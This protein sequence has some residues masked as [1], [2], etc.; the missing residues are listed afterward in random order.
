MSLADDD[1]VD[2]VYEAAAVGELW[3]DVLRELAV[4]TGGLGSVM[5]AATPNS[6]RWVASAELQQFITDWFREG[7]AANNTRGARLQSAQAAG[8]LRDIDVFDSRDQ[9]D[10]DPQVRDFLRPRGMGWAVGTVLSVPNGD[11]IIFSIEREYVKG[12]FEDA[13]VGRLDV[14]RPHLARAAVLSSR[15]GFERA[16]AVAQALQAVGLPTAVL[17]TGGR[18]AATNALFDKLMPGVIEDRRSRVAL[19]NRDSDRLLETALAKLD[20]GVMQGEV[21]SIAV[22]AAS[23]RSPMAL[24]LIPVCGVAHDIFSQAVSILIATPVDRNASPNAE[25]L[26][27]LFDLTRTEARIARAIAQAQSI[28]EIADLYGV[29]TGTVRNQL[30]SI[31]AKTGTGRQVELVRLLSGLAMRSGSD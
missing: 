13:V 1:L 8:F 18:L 17:R 25:L 16:R 31:F 24:H 10:N 19:V 9:M 14:L 12:P 29:S 3:P 22:P 6:S 26:E 27:G 28:Q 20:R 23:G 4:L 21:M 7:W 2:R 5:A 30:K 15:L 11:N